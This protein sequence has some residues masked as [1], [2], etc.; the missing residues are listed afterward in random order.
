MKNTAH[1]QAN[2]NISKNTSDRIDN[3]FKAY[4]QRFQDGLAGNVDVEGTVSAFADYFIE[5]SP[6]GVN[7]GKNDEEFRRMI[8]QGTDFYRKVGTKSMKIGSISVTPLNE[9]HYMVKVH[10]E[11]YYTKKNGQEVGIDF[12]VIY[13]LQD[14]NAALKVFAYITDDKQAVLQ[15]NGQIE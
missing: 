13:L 5:A 6:L 3:F 2:T 10:W 11:S 1:K 4:A 14:I 9:L 8:P 15:G 12:D 7:G